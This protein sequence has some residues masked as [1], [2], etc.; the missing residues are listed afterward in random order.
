[1]SIKK[2]RKLKVYGMG[3]YKGVNVPTIVLKGTW[4]EKLGFGIDVAIS[5]ECEKGKL[6]ISKREE[7]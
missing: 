6:V 1:M 2:E 7:Q 3:G 4:L 5:V